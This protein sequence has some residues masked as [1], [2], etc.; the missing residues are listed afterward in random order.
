MVDYVVQLVNAA[1]AYE[2]TFHIAEDNNTLPDMTST[3]PLAGDTKILLDIGLNR[4][5]S[6]TSTDYC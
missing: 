3:M 5:C 6:G 4:V 1:I 2:F